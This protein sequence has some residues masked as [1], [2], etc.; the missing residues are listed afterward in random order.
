M[1]AL[2]QRVSEA[3]VLVEDSEAGKIGHGAL[4][5]LGVEK[6]D[7]DKDALYLADKCAHLRIFEDNNGLMNCSIKD[8][9][10]EFLVVSQ[11][12]LCADCRKGRRPSFAGAS[13]P[14][15]GKKLYEKFVVILRESGFRVETGIFQAQMKVYLVNNG[16]VT[17]LLDSGIKK[18]K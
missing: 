16:P 17:I 14:E 4:I 5:F 11:F 12:T 9:K 3:S 1:K 7:T 13:T 15:E 18:S 8:V 2:I 6:G 10:G